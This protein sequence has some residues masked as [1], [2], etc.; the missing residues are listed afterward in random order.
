MS[1]IQQI[2]DKAA[3]LVFGLIALSLVGFLLMDAFVGRSRLFGG[4]STTVG[5]VNGEKLDYIKFE[6]QAKSRMEQMK[7]Q[8]YPDNEMMQKNVKDGVWRDYVEEVILDDVF[9][10]TGIGVGDRELNDMLAGN[11]AIPEIRRQ[12]TDPK[13]GIFDA[14]AA[15]SA[16]N[17]L[18]AIWKGNKKNDRGYEEARRFWEEGIP[19][20]VRSREKEKYLSMI[21]NSAYVPKWLAE[22]SNADNSL[23]ASI[24][25]VSAPY[26]LVA[27]SLVKISEDE[28]RDYVDKHKDQ[29]KQEES[30]IIAYVYY[31]AGPTHADSVNDRQQVANMKAD[32]LA[33][34]D[35]L[36]YIARIGS[37]I[38]SGDIYTAKS[39]IQIP[40]KDSILALPIGGVYGPYLDQNNYVLAKKVDEKIMPDSVKAR[41]ILVATI[42]AQT[43]QPTMDDSTAK[44]KIDSIQN[45]IAKGEKFDSLA[46]KLSDDQGSKDKGGD[47]GYFT[48]GTMVKEF[49]DFCFTGKKGE[50]KVVKTQFGYHLIEITDQK[51]FEPAYKIAYLAKT[52]DASPET[53]GNASG[54]ANQFAGESRNQKSFDENAKK[55]KLPR[56]VS[57]EIH[58]TDY[59]IPGL[60][61]SPQLVRW[62]FEA[63]VGDVS[64]PIKVADKYVVALV[65]EVNNEGT[66]SAAKARLTVE[67]ILR[68]KKK[69]DLIIK[70]TPNNATLESAASAWNQQVKNADSIA[71]NS[72]YVPGLGQEARVI[73]YAF[74]KQ[75]PGKPAS[76]PIEGNGGVFIIKVNN[77]SARANL[78][79]DI[80]QARKSQE[81]MQESILQRQAMDELKKIATI[82]DY[83]GKFY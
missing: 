4:N 12:F 54:M 56:L 25:Y 21:A 31:N 28:I 47:L 52:I 29:Y 46:V 43:H 1:I 38:P 60:G 2:R 75:M 44:K 82:K 79:G 3:W 18:R 77:V 78:G 9:E 16:I 50:S 51:E 19:Q 69:A 37:D 59:M 63:S 30:R 45:L 23:M 32:F 5:S 66:M 22:K 36:A 57:Q 15:A 34:K 80:A 14:Q 74:N 76:P 41:H 58:P 62:L 7:A 10:K 73:G 33:A 20:I 72:P 70:K 61:S 67:P 42:D 68:N 71:F 39:K 11:N 26:S 27:D 49:N 48:Q 65:T 40:F 53:D 81:Q 35:A 8:G 6:T 83:R 13:T 24:S 17:Q 55:Q 64:V